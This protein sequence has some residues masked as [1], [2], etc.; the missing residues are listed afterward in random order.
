LRLWHALNGLVLLG[1]LG[2]VLLR[3]TFLSW[4]TNGPLIAAKVEELGGS[5]SAEGA[6]SVAKAIR[7]PMW[8][9]HHTFGLML[10]ALLVWRLG[11][12]IA[13]PAD[14]PW[15]QLARAARGPGGVHERLVLA[16]YALFYLVLVAMAGSGLLLTYGEGVGVS[17][18]AL[19]LVKEAHEWMMWFFPSFLALHVGGVVVAELRGDHGLVSRMIHGAGPR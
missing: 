1:S 15:S 8:D 13:R 12:S 14:A 7:A 9:W 4:R 11:W 10:V 2:T 16:L 17:E 6:V 5:V 18:A 19:S 3:K